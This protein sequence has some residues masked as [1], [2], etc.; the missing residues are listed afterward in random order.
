[1]RGSRGA[2]RRSSGIPSLASGDDASNPRDARPAGRPAGRLSTPFTPFHR[3]LALHHHR[4][5]L[6]IFLSSFLFSFLPR[7]R[8]LND[9]HAFSISLSLSPPPLSVSRSL[10]LAYI[11]FN[12]T[13]MR[14]RRLQ[15]RCLFPISSSQFPSGIVAPR[16][17]RIV[18]LYFFFFF[19]F[20]YLSPLLFSI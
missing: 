17:S 4:L 19:F 18:S 11:G 3:L 12:G 9:A 13:V 14:R 7:S 8:I 6:S 15:L 16:S 1:M 10:L 20:F 2:A 5:F